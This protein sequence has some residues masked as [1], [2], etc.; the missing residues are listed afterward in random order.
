MRFNV[1]IT[2]RTFGKSDS[3]PIDM[4]KKAGCDL[5]QNPSDHILDEDELIRLIPEAHGL[6]VGLDSVSERV[7]SYGGRLRVISK[8]GVG[9]DNIDL[10]AAT[11]MGIMVVNSPGTNSTAVAELSLGLMLNLARHVSFS[12]RKIREGT[13]QSYKGFELT[14]K[15]LGII[16]TGRTGKELALKAGGFN[17]K[18]VC[19][20]IKKDETWA[21]Q[22]GAEYMPMKKVLKEADILS[23]HI[24]LSDAT[25]HIIS[26]Q[27]LQ[28]MKEN[29]ILIN[30]ARG[31]LIEETAL[32]RALK[33]RQLAGAGLDVWET[34]PPVDS[35]LREL[36]NVVL[37]SHI[38]AHTIEAT[39]AMGRLAS[40]NLIRA[41]S[42][43]IPSYLVN[44]E[45]RKSKRLRGM[46][47]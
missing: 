4:L 10:A 3:A 18:M 13:W 19:Y 20:D 14:G 46:S 34:T 41:L 5:I 16:G 26:D 35:P 36:D 1:L 38:G 25:H 24:P 30:T 6:I 21:R 11:R 45:V 28:L 40:Q 2:P 7:L 31:E 23:L 12:D 29:A 15:T 22:V 32:Y 8:Y 27:E 37:T 33:N 47:K 42:G 39:K 17:M 43:E 9:T 44:P